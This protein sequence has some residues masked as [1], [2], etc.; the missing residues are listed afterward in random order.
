MAR[1]FEPFSVTMDAV[2]FYRALRRRGWS[3]EK[4][5]ELVS[6][7]TGVNESNL[8]NYERTTRPA[9]TSGGA[10]KY[11]LRSMD[12]E[13]EDNL[14]RFA[15]AKHRWGER[16]RLEGLETPEELLAG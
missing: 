15:S 14:V 4:T 6:R 5:L 11:D 10:R 16:A 12:A 8:E 3:H 2:I 1:K 13:S 7:I 9:K